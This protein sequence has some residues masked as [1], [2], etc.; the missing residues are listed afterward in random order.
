MKT[1]KPKKYIGIDPKIILEP[2]AEW[3]RKNGFDI[4]FIKS[5]KKKK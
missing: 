1:K 2:I 3:A 4:Y 5:P